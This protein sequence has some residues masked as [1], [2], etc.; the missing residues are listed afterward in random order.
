MQIRRIELSD[1]PDFLALWAQVYSEGA[2]LAK[3]PPPADRARQVVERVVREQIPNFVATDGSEF[4]GAVEVFPAAMC[5]IS[6]DDSDRRGYLGIQ[7]AKNYRGKGIGRELMQ[8]VIAD[9]RRYGF[10]TIEL[11]V[12][13]SNLAA[14]AL[15]QSLGFRLTGSSSSEILPAGVSTMGQHM[16]LSL[17]FTK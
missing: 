7:L 16:A 12:F 10:E 14:I 17:E 11:S 15:Y 3:G 2:F 4:I 13:Q 5:G 1:V 9:A 8:T 6:V